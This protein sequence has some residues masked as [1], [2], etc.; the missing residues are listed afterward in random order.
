LPDPIFRFLDYTVITG[1]REILRDGQPVLVEP[2]VY[3]LIVC[4][5][6]RHERAVGKEELQDAIWPKVIVTESALTRCVMKARQALG[7]DAKRPRVI[8]TVSRGG[9]RFV[10]P[11]ERLDR[12]PG[13]AVPASRSREQTSIAVLPFANLSDSAEHDYIASGLTLDISTDL[14]RNAWLFVVSPGSL[15]DYRSLEVDYQ[16]LVDAFGVQYVVEGSQRRAGNK[17]RINAALVDATTGAR[18]WS[19]R[20]DQEIADLFEIQDD[21][22]QQIVASLGSQV[23]RAEGRKSVRADSAALDVW[24]LL[25]KGMAT[26]WS[27]FNR[28]SN[29]AAEAI[30]REALDIE[31]DNGRA[32]AFLAT[33]IAMKVSNGWSDNVTADSYA[34][35]TLGNKAV[36][37]LPDDPIVLA[38]YGHLCTCLGQASKAV[39]VL[40]RS[41]ELDPNSAWSMGLLAFALTCCNRADEAIVHLTTALHLSPRDAAVHWYLAMLAWAYLHQAH[42]DDAAREAQRSIN[43]FSGWSVAWATLAVARAGLGQFD[44]ARQALETCRKL[45]EYATRDGYAK[46]FAYIVRDGAGRTAMHD[47]LDEL[48][49]EAGP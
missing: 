47:W 24:G 36:D 45:D 15:H 34:A 8:A 10:A 27:R 42:Y 11:L 14:S 37:L 40:T 33:S 26:S 48:W 35:W 6:E 30:Y 39:E 38:R 16:Q 17:L 29:L 46:F 9:Y 31:P 49:V 28:E 18:E 25:H 44:E 12:E 13:G 43:A 2:K 20:Y 5:L 23:R 7:D 3:E 22:T 19:E 4:L 1:R 41:I 21:I 32:M